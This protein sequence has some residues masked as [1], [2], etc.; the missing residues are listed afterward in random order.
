MV[1]LILWLLSGK[2]FEIFEIPSSSLFKAAD[3]AKE[4]CQR[5]VIADQMLRCEDGSNAVNWTCM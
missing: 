2:A 4:V 1:A 5:I 3:I